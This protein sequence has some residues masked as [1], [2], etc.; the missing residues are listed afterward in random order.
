MVVIRLSRGGSNK[1]PFYHIVVTDSRKPRDSSYIERIGYYNPM[2]RGS[3][4]RLQVEKERVVYWTSKGAIASERVTYLLDQLEKSPEAAQKA[5]LRRNDVKKQ[6]IEEATKAHKKAM[7]E[8]KKVEEVAKAEAA[9]A[10]EAKAAEQT[11][12]ASEKAEP[13]TEANNAEASSN[14]ESK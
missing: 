5:A 14:E 6:Q 2:A 4:I 9:A 1:N 7:V 11:A 10:Q 3:D 12:E 13:K 8:A